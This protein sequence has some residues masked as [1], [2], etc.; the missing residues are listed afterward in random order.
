LEENKLVV[1]ISC[2]VD[3]KD[4]L[5]ID[6]LHDKSWPSVRAHYSKE[7]TTRRAS[8]WD[9][10]FQVAL[11]QEGLFSASQA[12]LVGV[13]QQLLGRYLATHK[14][15]RVQRALYRVV[16]FPRGEH[17]DL[18]AIWLWTKNEGVFSRETALF[19]HQLSDALPSRAQITLPTAWSRRTVRIPEGVSVYFEDLHESDRTWIGPV[20][21]TSVRRTLSDCLYANVS[22]DLV[23]Q[24]SEEAAKRGLISSSEVVASP[25]IGLFRLRSA[26]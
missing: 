1:V 26:R 21:V 2:D 23:A 22:P 25:A 8:P 6:V 18:I 10:L 15:E 20:P 12:K 17:E 5:L 19:L 9:A 7:V 24:A 11:E 3:E 4:K 16:H 14:V 13:S